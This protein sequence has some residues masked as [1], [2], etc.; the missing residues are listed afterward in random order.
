MI[1]TCISEGLEDCERMHDRGWGGAA[2]QRLW[3]TV[4]GCM[5]EGGEGLGN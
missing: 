2:F 4:S 3:K 5:I 1:G